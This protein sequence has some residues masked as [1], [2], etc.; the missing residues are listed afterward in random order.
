MLRIILLVVTFAAGG[1]A[2]AGTAKFDKGMTPI[3]SQYLK[4]QSALASDK[5]TGVKNASGKII[6]L[7]KKLDPSSL[8]GEHAGHYK[9]IPKNLIRQAAE[10]RQSG[11]IDAA[12][13]HFKKLSQP[14]A[15]W[16]GMSKPKGVK[17]A[18][19]PMAKASWLQEDSGIK[20]PYY[21]KKMLSC[22]EFVK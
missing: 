2:L 11:S 16:A 20:N 10:I 4:I 1:N 5:L 6:A 22:G 12:R 8:T 17:V 13:E 9:D 21:G 15:M 14:M 7:A 3:L 18:Y 19:C